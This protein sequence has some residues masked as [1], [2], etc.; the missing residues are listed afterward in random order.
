[1]FPRSESAAP[2]TPQHPPESTSLFH[3]DAPS[4][5]APIPPTTATLSA[6][7][8]TA[9]RTTAETP[10]LLANEYTAI[11]GLPITLLDPLTPAQSMKEKGNTAYRGLIA[12][13]QALSDCS[14][15]FLPLKTAC[16]VIL[17]IHKTFDVRKISFVLYLGLIFSPGSQR[18]ST[19]RDQ[20][21]ELEVKLASILEIVKKYQQHDGM[22][23]LQHR[24]KTFCQCVGIFSV[25]MPS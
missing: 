24:I 25:F 4:T 14:D 3:N 21:K 22:D 5:S 8:P 9:N 11:G 23:A 12:I 13:V 15:I 18:V 10:N 2:L 16:N 17:T 20:L 7:Q 6:A 1:M 19:N